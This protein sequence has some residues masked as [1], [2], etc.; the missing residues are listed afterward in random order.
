MHMPV[1][2]HVLDAVTSL[3][4]S[5]EQVLRRW[6]ATLDASNVKRLLGVLHQFITLRIFMCVP[7]PGRGAR[8]APSGPA[9]TARRSRPP[10]DAARRRVRARGP[11]NV[12][13]A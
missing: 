5:A 3:P 10:Q 12:A 9:V 8:P 11:S 4:R 1:L 7:T 13:A 6:L 2:K